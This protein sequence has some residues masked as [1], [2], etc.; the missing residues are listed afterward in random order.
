DRAERGLMAVPRL[1]S[2]RGMYFVSFD[3]DVEDLVSYLGEARSYIDL[4]M[5]SAETLGGW[6]M[7]AGSAKFTLRANWKLLIENSIDGYHLPTVHQTYIDYMDSRLTAVGSDR[8][9]MQVR[10]GSPS[11]GIS[12]A[13]GHGGFLHFSPG[14]T[15]ANSSPLWSEEARQEVAGIR[16]RLIELYGEGR[17]AE[18]ADRSRHLLIF[19]NLLFQD[20]H[21]GMRFR[22]VWPVA[23]DLLEVTQTD[24][25][26]RDESAELRAYRLEWSRA[27]LGPG[28]LA[29]PDDVEALESCQIGFNAR[30]LEWSDISR[31]MH[32][33]PHSSDEIQMRGFWREWQYRLGGRASG[34]EVGDR[35]EAVPSP[36]GRGLG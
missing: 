6:V 24:L 35:A 26:P 29:T 22:Q 25:V 12:F 16:Q 1:D 21:T 7:V 4:T 30:E 31:G 3:P 14:R 23:P 9:S 34:S 17:G 36:V 10:M 19:P 8:L 27:F 33:R 2:Y 32:R 15:V 18:M 20:S 5:D 11:D 13:R 28:G